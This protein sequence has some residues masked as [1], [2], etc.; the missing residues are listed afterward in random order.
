MTK[1]VPAANLGK[2]IDNVDRWCSTRGHFYT[3]K[4]GEQLK[5]LL[6]SG[7]AANLP[8]TSFRNKFHVFEPVQLLLL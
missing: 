1:L 3:F 8:E 7:T 4:P 5:R 2:P 6:K